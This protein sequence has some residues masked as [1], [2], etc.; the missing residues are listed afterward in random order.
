M[1]NGETMNKFM[2]SI[3]KFLAMDLKA[4]SD[5]VNMIMQ[6]YVGPVFTALGACAVVFLVVQ[7]VQ[8]AKTEDANKREEVKKK[9]INAAIGMVIIIGLAVLSMSLDWGGIVNIFGYAGNTHWD[10][11]TQ[12]WVD[13]KYAGAIRALLKI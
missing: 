8:Y 3:S 11:E 4:I 6:E 1:K 13:G 7:G 10:P 5:K 2:L 12:S 9:I